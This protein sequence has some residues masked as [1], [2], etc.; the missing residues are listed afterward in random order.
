MTPEQEAFVARAFE[1][2]LIIL[3]EEDCDGEEWR[4]FF[5]CWWR[6]AG[7]EPYYWGA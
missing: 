2:E 5:G 3:A 4:S 1:W 7:V 6:N